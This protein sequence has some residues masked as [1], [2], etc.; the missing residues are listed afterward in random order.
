MPVRRG[1]PPGPA[2]GLRAV[3]RFRENDG[4]RVINFAE[5]VP[6]SMPV[7]E[8]VGRPYVELNIGHFAIYMYGDQKVHDLTEKAAAA[9]VSTPAGKKK[10][11]DA[12]VA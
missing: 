6:I 10:K 1:P 8:Q 11:A 5:N 3:V 9:E 7:S 2:G 12:R 4:K